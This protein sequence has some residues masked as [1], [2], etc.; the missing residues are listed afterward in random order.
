MKT[1]SKMWLFNAAVCLLCIA[2]S[3]VCFA[4]SRIVFGILDIVLGIANG[5]IA[6]HGYLLNK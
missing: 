3:V 1:K 5:G 4:E 6:I 2:A